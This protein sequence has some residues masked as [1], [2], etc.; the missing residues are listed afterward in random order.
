MNAFFA[1]TYLMAGFMFGIGN[2]DACQKAGADT[3]G[4]L[5]LV[6]AVVWPVDIGFRLGHVAG[7]GS[8]ALSC[9]FR[10]AP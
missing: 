7:G 8:F 5:P 9:E 2:W 4:W 1:I 3:D 10:R 6:D